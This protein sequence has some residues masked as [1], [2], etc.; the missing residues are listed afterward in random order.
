MDTQTEEDRTGELQL[1]R[2]KNERQAYMF[3]I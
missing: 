1:F 2:G 3:D